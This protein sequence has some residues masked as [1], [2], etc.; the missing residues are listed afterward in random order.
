MYMGFYVCVS[1]YVCVHICVCV[2]VC[3]VSV[4]V[5]AWVRAYVGMCVRVT[6]ELLRLL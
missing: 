3:G 1:V 4:C 6:Y 5:C 2:F